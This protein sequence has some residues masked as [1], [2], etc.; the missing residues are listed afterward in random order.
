MCTL[1]RPCFR[2]LS[3]KICGHVTHCRGATVGYV[4]VDWSDAVWYPVPL[5]R[6]HPLYQPLLGIQ[7]TFQ[8]NNVS[9]VSK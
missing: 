8:V 3:A 6:A 4:F 7:Q 2:L 9:S 5:E 1:I